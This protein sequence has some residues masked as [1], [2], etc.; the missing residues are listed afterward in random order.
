M[1]SEH[2]KGKEAVS[3]EIG[4]FTTDSTSGSAGGGEGGEPEYANLGVR[5]SKVSSKAKPGDG[6]MFIHRR[7][8]ER[9]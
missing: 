8:L 4:N 2:V 9:K 3:E 6:L 7:N 5:V 1:R